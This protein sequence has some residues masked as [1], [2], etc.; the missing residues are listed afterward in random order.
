MDKLSQ[1]GFKVATRQKSAPDGYSNIDVT[2]DGE[3]WEIKSPQ[4]TKESNPESLR[5]VEGNLRKAVEQFR[6]QYD[7]K[8]GKTKLQRAC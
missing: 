1:S 7:N 6:S 8:S 2:I 5:F 4:D 3:L